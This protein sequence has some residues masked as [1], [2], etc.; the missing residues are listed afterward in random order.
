MLEPSTDGDAQSER[1]SSHLV[2]LQH[3]TWLEAVIDVH[4]LVAPPSLVGETASPEHP[5]AIS[6]HK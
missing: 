2:Y 5:H 1:F 4:S 3:H 6:I